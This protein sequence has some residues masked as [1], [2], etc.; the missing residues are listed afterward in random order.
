MSKKYYCE[1]V[2]CI[3]SAL[4]LSPSEMGTL[5]ET[6]GVCETASKFRNHQMS[7]YIMSYEMVVENTAALFYIATLLCLA[8]VFRRFWDLY[9]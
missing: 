2:A 8:L 7:I 6:D 1:A 5:E 3:P 9:L 4:D